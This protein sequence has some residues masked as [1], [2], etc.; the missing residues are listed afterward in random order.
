L[1]ILQ[2]PEF[3]LQMNLPSGVWQVRQ[4][5]AQ[6]GDAFERAQIFPHVA[7]RASAID[8]ARSANAVSASANELP[9]SVSLFACV[10]NI[11]ITPVKLCSHGSTL[12]SPPRLPCIAGAS[13]AVS[14][15][16]L[17]SP[18]EQRNRAS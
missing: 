6:F 9:I 1:I 12:G 13:I 4:L 8:G 2:L 16:S 3:G 7:S 10:K 11:V 17:A 15:G 18:I 14:S 5:L